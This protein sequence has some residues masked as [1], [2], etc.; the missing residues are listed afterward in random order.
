[1]FR[2]NGNGTFTRVAPSAWPEFWRPLNRVDRHGCAAGDVNRD[3][4]TDYECAVGRTLANQV[5]TAPNDNELWLQQRDGGFTDVGTA[6][7]V[8]DP[9]GRGS[10][11]R[12]SSTRTETASKT[13]TSRTS[14]P[15]QTTQMGA[16]V[17]RQVLPERR[18]NSVGL[19]AAVRSRPVLGRGDVRP[20]GG[21]QPGWLA[22]HLRVRCRRRER[23]DESS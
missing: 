5:K 13:F 17:V 1:M 22:G 14:C 18:G 16:S 3:G 23:A 6:W 2:N 8:G 9:R 15:D 12:C 20:E 10:N 19:G 4:R 11:R 21:F 7:G